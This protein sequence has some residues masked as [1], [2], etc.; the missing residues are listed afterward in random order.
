M[1]I[2]LITGIFCACFVRIF[3]KIFTPGLSLSTRSLTVVTLSPDKNI[4]RW[5]PSSWTK[6]S[7]FSLI[8][9]PPDTFVN[10]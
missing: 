6:S 9:R 3:G 5:Q 8:L 7:R 10:H 1:I 2:S 4:H